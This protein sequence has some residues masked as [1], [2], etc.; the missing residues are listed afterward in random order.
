LHD[1]VPVPAPLDIVPGLIVQVRPLLGEIAVD[2][3]TVPLN[4]LSG[5]TTIVEDAET[6][7]F[8]FTVVGLA[9]RS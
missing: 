3:L 8:M 1:N 4:P 6:P 2:R 5:E 9:V 7:E